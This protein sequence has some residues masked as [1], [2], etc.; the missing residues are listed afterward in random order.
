MCRCSPAVLRASKTNTSSDAV[1]E[2][3]IAGC[4]P[5]LKNFDALV[6]GIP[7][8]QAGLCRAD[9][10][11][12]HACVESLKPLEIQ[13]R[14]FADLREKKAGRWACRSGGRQDGGM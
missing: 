8:L 1:C 5:S 11:W 14:S 13:Q 9:H 6:H 2:F 7:R 4:T 3:V 12:L 10:E